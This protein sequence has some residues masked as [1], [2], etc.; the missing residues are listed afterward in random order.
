MPR[1][2]QPATLELPVRR[3]QAQQVC[4]RE[5]GMS[6]LSLCLTSFANTVSEIGEDDTRCAKGRDPSPPAHTQH[7]CD[8]LSFVYNYRWDGHK[9]NERHHLKCMTRT[10]HSTTVCKVTKRSVCCNY[11]SRTTGD[12]L[13]SDPFVNVPSHSFSTVSSSCRVSYL[14]TML[15]ESGGS[16]QQHCAFM[17]TAGLE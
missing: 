16:P 10:N 15:R 7:L 5:V 12:L 4:I 1:E 11:W 14:Q 3:A 2:S 17:I 6:R 9:E 13:H 8:P